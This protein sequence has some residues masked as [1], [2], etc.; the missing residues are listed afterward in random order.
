MPMVLKLFGAM[1][2]N[3]LYVFVHEPLMVSVE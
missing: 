2:R 1:H 3:N